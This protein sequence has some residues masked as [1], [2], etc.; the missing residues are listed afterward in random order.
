MSEGLLQ[1]VYVAKNGS[2]T[3]IGSSIQPYATIQHALQQ[4]PINN[5]NPYTI[6]IAPGV[7]EETLI[8]SKNNISII[9]LSDDIT[10]SC[11]IR[12]VGNICVNT[13]ATNPQKDMIVLHNIALTAPPAPPDPTIVAY[14]LRSMGQNYTLCLKN[15]MITSSN[16]ST[17]VNLEHIDNS[18]RVVFNN[19]FIHALGDGDCIDF[20]NGDVIG[21]ENCELMAKGTGSAVHII[22][23][24]MPTLSAI[25]SHFVTLG[26]GIPL[27]MNAH[28]RG[29]QSMFNGCTIAAILAPIEGC[30]IHCGPDS[31]SQFINNIFHLAD[32]IST[33]IVLL[34]HNANI[35]FFNN[36]TTSRVITGKFTPFCA[37]TDAG[38][39]KIVH[40]NNV[41]TNGTH[42]PRV[43]FR[44]HGITYMHANTRY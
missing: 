3:Y 32:N 5:N 33:H 28:S 6:F 30:L 22:G 35:N 15:V 41:F 39:I 31:H 23:E 29:L 4:I 2:D 13:I 18:C 11:S 25:H 40:G 26:G 1:C 19:C 37:D 9:G 27:S 42:R 20:K 12:I 24:H 17:I 8:I 7:Y 38:N 43:S 16:T 36:I 10:Q 21:I 44:P 14:V 34:G